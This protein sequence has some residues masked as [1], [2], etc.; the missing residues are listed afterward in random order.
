MYK[1]RD[2]SVRSS[3]WQL[4]CADNKDGKKAWQLFDIQADPGEKLDVA[5]Q[6]PDVVQ[7]LDAAYD[8]WWKSVQSQLVN[9]NA[10]APK[11]NP[12][13]DLFEQQFGKLPVQQK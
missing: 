5:L 10:I 6:H 2:C 4:V 13:R 7:K 12:F 11:T 8:A 1:Y 9:E 3:R